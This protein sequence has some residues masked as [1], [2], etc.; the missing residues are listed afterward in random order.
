MNTAAASHHHHKGIGDIAL[1]LSGGGVRAVGFHLGTLEMLDR[2]DLL[3]NVK[4]LSTVSGGSLTGT[5]YALSQHLGYGFD[6]YF[7]NFYD[8][9]PNL[10]TI[11]RLLDGL[12]SDEQPAPSGRR[13]MITVMANIYDDTY[14]SKYFG[15]GGKS[16]GASPRFEV[17]LKP[18]APDSHLEEIIFN[19][20]E[21]QTGSAFR[22]QR[23]NWR[24]LV[25]NASIILCKKHA[26]QIRMAD[27]MAASS[28]IPAGMEPLFFPHDFH[29]P[30]D[31]ATPGGPRPTCDTIR[32][33]LQER[34]HQQFRLY[35]G[36]EVDF[37][38]LMD[39]GV[40]D[41]QGV[42]SVLLAMN[43][44]ITRFKADP[45]KV[46]ECGSALPGT[47]EESQ[48]DQWVKWFAGKVEHSGEDGQSMHVDEDSAA[49]L[50]IISDTPVRKDSQYPKIGQPVSAI[51]TD[52][53]QQAVRS[54]GRINRLTIGGLDKIGWFIS[55]LLFLSAGVTFYQ[56][57]WPNRDWDGSNLFSIVDDLL[58]VVIPL[59]ITLGI[60]S[61]LFILRR[62]IREAAKKVQ[63]VLPP[64]RWQK[65]DPW[66]YVKRLRLKDLLDMARLRVGSV[67]ALTASIFMG[68][69]RTLTY[70]AAYLREN[71]ENHI[72]ANQIFALECHDD[73]SDPGGK[74]S[75]P[76]WPRDFPQNISPISAEATAI[77]AMAAHL[78]TKLW[79]NDIGHDNESGQ[80]KAALSAPLAAATEEV[81]KVNDR[82]IRE[83]KAPLTDLDVL[84]IC[85]QMTICYKLMVHLWT[86]HRENGRWV[87]AG[88][89]EAIFKKCSDHW[90]Q[91]VADPIA[92]LDE[93]KARALQA[94]A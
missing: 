60:A 91:M 88:E 19:A 32:A 81:C 57:I 87:D 30:D 26:A 33:S 36:R 48:P 17:L 28:C 79:I 63:S 21:F 7:G 86:G 77:C 9:L 6:R 73:A 78:P 83:G 20:T 4:I 54:E 93:R 51:D 82:R 71:V 67:S 23:S 35:R 65:S 42:V 24:C 53:N 90:N 15:G 59:I 3:R 18:G 1:S 69:I 49:T 44:R 52:K 76:D 92:L 64:D 2:L 89:S 47:V 39:G 5:G 11:E 72:I 13:D 74:R 66:D 38:A 10:N 84:V 12:A 31:S 56:E 16:G 94:A 14:F 41:N 70:A 80:H 62:K 58:Q 22:F 85:G 68:R 40:Y 61:G 34:L 25:G 29:W 75:P 45:A 50:I 37:F 46:L 8:F 27:I 43:R 55:T